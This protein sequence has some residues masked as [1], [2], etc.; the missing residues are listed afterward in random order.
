MTLTPEQC[1]AGRAWLDWSQE[2]L[3]KAAHVSHSTVRDFEK[4]RRTPVA[5]NLAAMEAA[6][7]AQGIGF[8]FVTSSEPPC[9][10]G[11]SFSDPGEQKA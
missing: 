7:A 6:L 1:R 3:A 2:D 11:I 9:A 8:V 10:S 4:G 5:N